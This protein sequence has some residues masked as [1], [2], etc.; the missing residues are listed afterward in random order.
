MYD[1]KCYD[2]AHVFLDDARADKHLTPAE[3]DHHVTRLAQHVQDA[4]ENYIGYDIEAERAER[5]AKAN[6][7]HEQAADRARANDF[8]GGNDWT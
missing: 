8:Y 7:P 2:L 6:D 5:A 1:T 3:F 4:I